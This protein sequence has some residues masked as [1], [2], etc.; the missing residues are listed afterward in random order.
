MTR[1][2]ANELAHGLEGVDLAY[3]DPPYNSHSYYS[4][5]HVWETIVRGDDPEHYGTACKRVDC[6][7]TKSRYNSRREAW[8]A[9]TELLAALPTPWLIVS[10]SDEGFH[11]PLEL[12]ALLA[13]RGYVGLAEVESKRYVGAKIGIHNPRGEK[14]GTVGRLRNRELLFV[15]GPDGSAVESALA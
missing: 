2:D 11:D 13:E 15:V 1:L 3:L 5:Y 14:V 12:R 9:L 10:F 4:N 6:R 7:T 8:A